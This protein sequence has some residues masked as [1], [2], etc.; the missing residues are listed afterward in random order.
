VG[1]ATSTAA[2]LWEAG[3][4]RGGAVGD[5]AGQRTAAAQLTAAARGQ[6]QRREERARGNE[7]RAGFLRD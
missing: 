3:R 6:R 4:R 1:G 7:P 2:G 5:G